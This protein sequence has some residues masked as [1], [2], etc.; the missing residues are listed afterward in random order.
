MNKV[1]NISIMAVKNFGVGRL[2]NKKYLMLEVMKHFFLDRCQSFLW[3][4][5]RSSRKYLIR[6]FRM[7][8][9]S[10]ANDGLLVIDIN[11]YKYL[12][13]NNHENEVQI[14]SLIMTAIKSRTRCLWLNVTCYDI[15]DLI[16]FNAALELIGKQAFIEL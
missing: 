16:H 12:I 4:V 2:V 11:I 13:E 15:N 7:I 6:N 9:Q 5:N 1:L 8:K 10:F 3:E 14:A